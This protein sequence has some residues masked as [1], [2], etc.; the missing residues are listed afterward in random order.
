[1]TTALE[2]IKDKSHIL[3]IDHYQRT[4]HML[5]FYQEHSQLLDQGNQAKLW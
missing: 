1:M 3:V 4:H 5:L 2:N